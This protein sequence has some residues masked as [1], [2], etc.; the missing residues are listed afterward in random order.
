MYKICL[1]LYGIYGYFFYPLFALGADQLLRVAESAITH[2]CLIRGL[3]KK[4]TKYEIK[5]Q[6]LKETGYFTADEYDGWD[7]L[8]KVRNASSHSKI[9]T[10]FPAFEAISILRNIAGKINLLFQT[11]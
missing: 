8:R 5:L 1:F 6:K 7:L 11:V 3:A 4:S 10:V 2:K 9:Q